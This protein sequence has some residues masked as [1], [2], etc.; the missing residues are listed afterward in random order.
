MRW[1]LPGGEGGTGK[2]G[3][4]EGQRA[5]LSPIGHHLPDPFPT[6]AALRVFRSDI[7]LILKYLKILLSIRI[8]PISPICFFRKVLS[9]SLK[10]KVIYYICNLRNI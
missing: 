1:T 5:T 7:V 10:L 2:W 4:G 3:E 8:S 9:F 6:L